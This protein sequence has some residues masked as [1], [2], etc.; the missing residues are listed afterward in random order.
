MK[1]HI[2][3][4][5]FLF[6]CIF[7][8]AQ[9]EP[10]RV[11]TNQWAKL[12]RYGDADTMLSAEPAP[13][14]VVFVGNSI[15]DFWATSSPEF[16]FE[17][18][19]ICRGIS[20]QTTPQMLLR[21]RHDVVETGAETVVILAGTNDIAGN[22]GYSPFD[23]IAGFIADMCEIAIA[24][25]IRPLICSVLPAHCY[26]WNAD[27]HP[28]TDIPILNEK[29]KAYAENKG[30]EYVDFFSSLVDLEAE[31]FNGL[32]KKYS[33]DGVHPTVE[34][35]KVMEGVIMEYLKKEVSEYREYRENFKV[36]LATYNVRN[37]IGM[38]R[39]TFEGF[40]V[41]EVIGDYA[42]DVVALQELDSCTVRSGGVSIAERL[43]SLTGMHHIFAPAIEYDGGKY[44]VGMLSLEKP[45][46]YE[47][48]PLPGKEEAR[49]LLMVEF[50]RFIYCCTHLSLTEEDR[51]ASVKIINNSI[52]RFSKKIDKPV[53][54]AGDWNDCP[55]S[56][57]IAEMSR[58]F[59]ILTDVS[60]KTFPAD[61]PDCTIDYIAR[62][63]G[64]RNKELMN[65]S[66]PV[67]HQAPV[68]SD[69]LPV[70]VDLK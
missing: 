23:E 64:N 6:F 68:S 32:P 25:G 4:L 9:E 69:H 55:D 52:K 2:F 18:G 5:F 47:Y 49:V 22:N 56:E 62:W 38:D 53:F 13:G 30:I 28:E 45:I 26:Y 39:E 59:D 31:N 1:K 57:C 10:D 63:K 12:W 43:G 17:N 14:R 67:V 11:S 48:V 16:F 65:S 7:L 8:Y 20:A 29:L 66:N 51:I 41:A 37:C 46:R 27:I 21:F 36:R 61:N 24:N 40:R 44:G 15:T 54:I 35:Y 3:V 42:P 19:F 70:S 60:K 58:Y 33:E 50:E 34:G